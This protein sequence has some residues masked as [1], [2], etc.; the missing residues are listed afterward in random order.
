MLKVWLDDPLDHK[1][2]VKNLI[3]HGSF[4]GVSSIH[5]ADIAIMR[6]AIDLPPHYYNQAPLQGVLGNREQ[7][8]LFDWVWERSAHC[9]RVGI[10]SAG[11]YL[12]LKGGGDI[13]QKVDNHD[14]DHIMEV[15]GQPGRKIWVTSRHNSQM[16]PGSDATELAYVSER[17]KFMSTVKYTDEFAWRRDSST[18]QSPYWKDSEVLWYNNIKSLCWQPDFLVATG[19]N[20]YQ[21]FAEVLEAIMEK[22]KCAA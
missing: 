6:G 2:L 10:G 9:V 14:K 22:Q 1:Y 20:Q 16:L 3:P 12:N 13:I 17:N 19:A 5:D 4:K 11:H 18:S 8:K 15:E 7:I 21:F